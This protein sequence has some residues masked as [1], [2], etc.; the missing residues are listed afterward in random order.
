MQCG[1]CERE[2]ARLSCSSCSRSRAWPIRYDTLL[3]ITERDA[4]GEKVQEYLEST[5]GEIDLI[6][7]QKGEAKERIRKLKEETAK[8]REKAVAG[9]PFFLRLVDLVAHTYDTPMKILLYYK[10]SRR[11]TPNDDSCLRM[12]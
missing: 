11:K 5:R 9:S 6:A 1:V 12:R 7:V 4:A 2:T 8:L 10:Q 3:R